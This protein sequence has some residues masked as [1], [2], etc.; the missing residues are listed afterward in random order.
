[1]RDC[2]E[3][4][5][6]NGRGTSLA[7]ALARER[8]L[9]GDDGD[10]VGGLLRDALDCLGDEGAVWGV[11]G[12]LLLDVEVLCVLADDD[13][14]D[15]VCGGH[16]GLDG[17]DVCVEVEAL[18]EGDD[19]GGVALDGG[20]GGLDSAEEGAV[21]LVLEDLDGLVG[22]GGAGLLE[23]LEAGFEVDKVEFQAEAGWEGF[24]ETAAGGDDFLADAITGDEA[25]GG[26][27]AG[28]YRRGWEGGGRHQF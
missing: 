21:A 25:W 2:D 27:L 8:D 20:G 4:G 12:A 18:A 26:Q 10:A 28:R 13:H 9:S 24:E 14:V 23:G 1:M 5:G 19:G 11:V 17:A 15:W 3:R 16:D 6:V 22:E 7:D